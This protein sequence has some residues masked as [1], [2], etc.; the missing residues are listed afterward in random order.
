MKQTLAIIGMNF[1]GLRSRVWPALVVVTGM[2]CVVGV[3]LSMMSF[4]VGIVTAFAEAGDPG[5]AIIL[6]LSAQTEMQSGIARAVFPMV[7]DADGIAKDRDKPQAEA[8][9]VVTVPMVNKVTR[10]DSVMVLRGLGPQSIRLRP[11]FR[12]LAGR[13]F[14]PGKRELIV[15]RA[16][17]G[18][19]AGTA[20]GDKVLLPDGEWS[21]V[22]AFSMQGDITEGNFFADRDTMMA[23]NRKPT[24]NSV[25]VRLSSPADFAALK[26]AIAANPA[27]RVD[28][29]RDSDYYLRTTANTSAFLKAI[30]YMVGA[31]MA[32]GAVFA[33][34]N[35]MYGAVASRT[36]E[37]ATLR[38]LGFGG[39]PVV[40]S[41]VVE[42]LALCVTG[43]LIGALIAWALFDGNAKAV[44]SS[45][46]VLRVSP[47]LAMTGLIW[48][49]VVGLL[50][51]LPPAIRA[52]RLPI[53]T[54]LRAT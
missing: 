1:K 15:G 33:A 41:V 19:F 26:R 24:Y 29:E 7:A 12:L 14:V 8:E 30:A 23:A 51:G 27:L 21:I 13:M 18:Q 38:A 4:T 16:A 31:T 37:I 11:K 54:A 40:L 10:L 46:F 36:R 48:A 42:A 45:V 17:Q 49:L 32:I 34:L 44:N 3:L 47:D 39:T 22:G 6:S 20:I 43:A 35:T 9:A 5:R 2:A 52:A 50:G 25:L 53:A 28:I